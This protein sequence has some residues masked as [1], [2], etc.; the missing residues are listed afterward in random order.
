MTCLRTKVR[1]GKTVLTAFR[2]DELDR[3]LPSWNDEAD[4]RKDRDIDSADKRAEWAA[5]CEQ[6]R[7]L[8]RRPVR[9]EALYGWFIDARRRRRLTDFRLDELDKPLPGWNENVVDPRK[10]LDS[11]ASEAV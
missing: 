2:R 4:A 6:L 11:E 3:A 10:D 1:N 9:G 5:K 7:L 8:G